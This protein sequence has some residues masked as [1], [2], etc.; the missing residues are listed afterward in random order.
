MKNL[1]R[2]NK[3]ADCG[4]ISHDFVRRR[5]IFEGKYLCMVCN[6]KRLEQEQIEPNELEPNLD[7]LIE[8]YEQ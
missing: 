7:D 8:V 3:C 2:N 1:K 4:L 6:N 5:T